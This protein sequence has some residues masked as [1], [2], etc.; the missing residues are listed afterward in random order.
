MCA[1][2]LRTTRFICSFVIKIYCVSCGNSMQDSDNFCSACGKGKK[3]VTCSVQETEF[4]NQRDCISAYFYS[5]YNYGTICSFLNMY[6]GV[7][8]SERTL[9]RRLQSY[10]LKR[11]C[12]YPIHVARHLI[13]MEIKNGPPSQYG[14]RSIRLF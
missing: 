13:E 3:L 8:M 2:F 10:G 11:N 7:T 6:H 12:N 14:Y 1:Y 5:G 9:K 4:L